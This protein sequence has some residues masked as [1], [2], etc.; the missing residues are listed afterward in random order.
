MTEYK[1]PTEV[2]QVQQELQRLENEIAELSA[3]IDAATHRLLMLIAEYD[4][5]GGWNNGACR[6]CA[7]WLSW[8]TGLDLGAAREKVRVARA[9]EKLPS[10]SE[11]LR[12]G[13]ISYSKARA[14][15]RVATPET[16][17]KLLEVARNGSA[18]QVEK[19]V[20]AWRRADVAE[21]LRQANRQHERR[22][23][24]TYTDE[25]GML[26]IR[27]HL[28]PEVGAVLVRALEAAQEQLYRKGDKNVSVET[29]P[30]QKRADA[31]A[32]V[33]EKALAGGL[34]PANSGD[35]YQVVVHVDHE[36]LADPSQP[37]Q[38]VL[39]DGQAVSAETS[40]RLSC[41]ASKVVMVHDREGNVLDVG[42]KTRTV[43]PAIRRALESRDKTC[44]FPGCASKFCHA[45]HLEHWASGGETKLSN[46]ALICVRHHHSVHEEGYRVEIVD[47]ELR[48]FRPNGRL[49]PDAPPRPSP[50]SLDVVAPPSVRWWTAEPL[51]LDWAMSTLLYKPDHPPV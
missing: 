48:F 21:E 19:I 44:R 47:G 16:E 9:L 39:E 34:E 27:G 7:H 30:E 40:R 8:R 36:V 42:R 25:N 38:S 41:D 24:R 17:Q 37:G 10:V 43:P 23:L 11:A 18:S 20:R 14:V 13:E 33:A 49:I 6:S 29:S 46:L 15:T 22:S 31:L 12:R 3:S 5:R 32:L 4:R 45:H 26:V 28:S 50:R 1:D 51:D 2:A 35:R